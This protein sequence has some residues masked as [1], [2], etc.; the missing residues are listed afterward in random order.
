MKDL[1][2][3]MEVTDK[4]EYKSPVNDVTY[5]FC[6]KKCKETFDNNPLKYTRE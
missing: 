2:C 6:S 4:S 1:V 5:Y 3:G